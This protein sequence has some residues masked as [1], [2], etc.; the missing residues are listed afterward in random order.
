MSLEKD[1]LTARV[2]AD[3]KFQELVS[4]R[5]FFAWTLALLMVVIYFGF[6][7]TIA[8]HK[9]LLGQSLMGG[10]TTVGIPVGLG[11]IVSAFV[12]T[13]IYVARANSGF[14]EMTKQIVEKAKLS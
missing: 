5:S 13:G 4:K 3:P 7:L 2:K 8:F 10:V 12:L 11:V 14:D 9:E 1:A 6:V